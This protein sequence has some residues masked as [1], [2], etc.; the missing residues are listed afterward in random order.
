MSTTVDDLIELKDMAVGCAGQAVE[1]ILTV[2]GEGADGA[3]GELLSQ[4][5]AVLDESE[6]Y[7]AAEERD[8]VC[9]VQDYEELVAAEEGA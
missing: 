4:A 5:R 2:F 9:S 6:K 3:A 8:D 7:D 1:T